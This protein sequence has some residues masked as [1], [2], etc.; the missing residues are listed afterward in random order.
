[1]V[2]DGSGRAYVG[3]FGFDLPT[4]TSQAAARRRLKNLAGSLGASDNRPDPVKLVDR[5]PARIALVHP[6]GRVEAAAD[7]VD[8]PNG[9]VITPDGRTLIVAETLGRKL[10]SYGVDPATGRLSDRRTWANCEYP[11]DG[12]CLDEGGGVWAAN[13]TSN[14]LHRFR[15]TPNSVD[16][17]KYGEITHSVETSQPSFAAALGGPDRRTLYVLTAPDS[18]DALRERKAEGRIE[19]VHVPERGVGWP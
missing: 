3:N 13:P 1:M 10:T 18:N 2:V 4:Y 19:V 17:N 8:F 12:I 11:P 5:K 16:G 14:I 7:G 9:T 6:D 15:T